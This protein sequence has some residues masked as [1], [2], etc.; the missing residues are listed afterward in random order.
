GGPVI[1][2]PCCVPV[3]S[4]SPPPASSR[5]APSPARRKS[6]LQS[7]PTAAQRVE[8]RRGR[9]GKA[10]LQYLQ[11]EANVVPPLVVAEIV[12]VAHLIAHVLGDRSIELSFEIR[13]LVLDRIRLTLGE[14]W[15]AIE[16]A[17]F[18]LGE[19]THEAGHVHLASALARPTFKAVGIEK[20]HE[21]LE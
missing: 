18:L 21:Q 12:Q 13:E 19:A 16:L 9:G 7:L 14:E 15:C 6:C 20:A 1:R 2:R 8:D 3:L 4:W 5:R 10:A 11:G 17:Q